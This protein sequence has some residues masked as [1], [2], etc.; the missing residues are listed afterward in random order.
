M[1]YPV[2]L[3]TESPPLDSRFLLWLAGWALAGFAF[4]PCLQLLRLTL[5]GKAS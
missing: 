4:A 5:R 2:E 1:A 3:L